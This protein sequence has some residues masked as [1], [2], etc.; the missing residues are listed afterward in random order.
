M[1]AATEGRIRLA[2]RVRFVPSPKTPELSFDDDS[3]P[4]KKLVP[5]VMEKKLKSLEDKKNT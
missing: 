1:F 5:H 2:M 3:P 4:P